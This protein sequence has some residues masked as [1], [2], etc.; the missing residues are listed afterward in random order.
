METTLEVSLKEAS[1]AQVA[2]NDS[3]LKEELNQTNTNIW[4]LPPYNI[5]DGYECDGD[6]ELREQICML[7]KA[8]GIPEDEYSFINKD[9][10]D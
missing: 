6:D 5:N 7:F 1:K 3:L 2:I 9:T 10:E 8:Y 4:K